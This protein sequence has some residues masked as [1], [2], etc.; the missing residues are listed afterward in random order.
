MNPSEAHRD[1]EGEELILDPPQICHW[2]NSFVAQVYIKYLHLSVSWM[3]CIKK[4]L[5]TFVVV[6]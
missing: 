6:K 5:S 4:V 1:G 3:T 2:C